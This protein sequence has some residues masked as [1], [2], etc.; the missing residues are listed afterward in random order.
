MVEEE[1][2]MK[3]ENFDESKYPMTYKEYEKRVIELFLEST[4]SPHD[5][6]GKKYLLKEYG[7]EIIVDEYK[8]ACYYYDDPESPNNEFTDEG[9]IRQPVRILEMI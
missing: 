4:D 1:I 7:D 2:I 5:L 3:S 8:M 6:E 9:L